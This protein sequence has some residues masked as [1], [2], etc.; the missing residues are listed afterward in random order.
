MRLNARDINA[1]DYFYKVLATIYKYAR[2]VAVIDYPR[3]PNK[4]SIDLVASLAGSRDDIVN[5]LV[6]CALD[7]STVSKKEAAELKGLASVLDASALIV[8]EFLSGVKLE[9]GVVYERH[10]VNLVNLETL[11]DALSGKR[12]PVIIAHKDIFKVRIKGD[13]LRRKRLEKG[14]SLGDVAFYL[15]VSRKA[16]YEYEKGVMEPT[17]ERAQKLVELFGEDILNPINLLE[18]PR[19]VDVK[20]LEPF[21]APEEETLARELARIGYRVVHAKRTSVDLGVKRENIKAL[22]VT[23]R[24]RESVSSIA[25]RIAKTERF[26]G[27]VSSLFLFVVGERAEHGKLKS[28]AQEPLTPREALERLKSLEYS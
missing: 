25:E 9:S 1:E 26:S 18:P 17:V 3:S 5:L 13:E 12:L 24:R 10:G 4:R 8:S 20:N 6:K 15:G 2:E 19:G 28:I 7:A 11:E 21:D 23:V 27:V 14:L 22:V 16:V